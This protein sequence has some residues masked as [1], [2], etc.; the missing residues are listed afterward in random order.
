MTPE[1]LAKASKIFDKNEVDLIA[2]LLLGDGCLTK[3][4][5]INIRHGHAQEEYLNWKTDLINLT[6]NMDTKMYVGKQCYQLQFKRKDLIN[7]YFRFYPNDKKSVPSILKHIKNP[8]DAIVIWLC[9]DGNVSP[10]INQNNGKCYSSSFQIFTFTDLEDT[11]LICDWWEQNIGIRP[12]AHFRDRSKQGKKS[13]YI[14]KFSSEDTRKIFYLIKDKI[15]NIKCMN[16][17]FRYLYALEYKSPR[18]RYNIQN[19]EKIV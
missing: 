7:Y 1:N 18:G 6:C 15:P 11:I 14:L 9:D 17:K 5:V 10:S 16:Y 2:S 3:N 19:V 8:L 13:A 12:K 4:G